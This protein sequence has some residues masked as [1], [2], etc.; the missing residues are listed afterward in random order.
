MKNILSKALM[1]VC[2]TVITFAAVAQNS[3]SYQGVIREGGKIVENKSVNLRLSVMLDDKVYYSEQQV[4]TTN[5]YG[6]V[7]VSVGEGTPLTGKFEDIPWQSMRVMLQVEVST[8]GTDKY[9]NMGSMQIQPVPYAFYA[10]QASVIQPA[11]ASDEP[12][13]QVKDNAGNLLFAVYETGVKVYV[14]DNDNSKAAKS[15]FA[16]AGLSANK[17]EETLLTINADGTTVFVDDNANSKAAKSKFAVSS[18]NGKGEG[19]LLS[20][21]GSGSTIYVG[22]EGK[23]AKSKFAVA[24][25][26]AK[27]AAGNNYS[28]DNDGSTVYVD[29][30]DN[31]SKSATQVLSIDGSS[32]TFYVDDTKEGKAAKSGFAVAG[33]S[34]DKS[35][36]TSLIIDGTGTLIYINNINSD[37]EGASRFVVAGLTANNGTNTNSDKFFTINRD[38]T[39]IYINDAPVTIDT[40]GTEP[41]STPVVMPSLASTFAIV[42]MTQKTD[43]L[44][45]NKDSTSIKV[46]TYVAEEV[47][48]TTGVVEKVVDDT[49]P[50]KVYS[51]GT[52]FL[53]INN[54]IGYEFPSIIETNTSYAYYHSKI[55]EYLYLKFSFDDNEDEYRNYWLYDGKIYEE[56]GTYDYGDKG[57]HKGQN[58]FHHS[59]KNDSGK[60]EV[61]ESRDWNGKGLLMLMERTL[62]DSGFSVTPLDGTNYFYLKD[63]PDNYIVSSES[64]IITGLRGDEDNAS[65]VEIFSKYMGTFTDIIY[66]F[67]WMQYFE[68]ID[69]NT[70]DWGNLNEEQYGYTLFGDDINS[71]NI[72]AKE[73]EFANGEDFNNEEDAFYNRDDSY[74]HTLS[75]I[76]NMFAAMRDGVTVT[77]QSGNPLYGSVQISK[78]KEKYKFGETITITA[79][80]LKDCMFTGWS[81]GNTQKSRT[82]T[83]IKDTELSANFVKLADDDLVDLGLSV[84]WASRNLGAEDI[85]SLG[86]YYVWGETEPIDPETYDPDDYNE[87]DTF[88][89]AA[90]SLLGDDYRVP[91]VDDWQELIDSCDWTFNSD[92]AF[93]SRNG[94]SIFLPFIDVYEEDY[95]S[96]YHSSYWSRTF[97]YYDNEKYA[98]NISINAYSYE[99]D[100]EEYNEVDA[101]MEDDNSLYNGFL[102][103]PVANTYSVKAIAVGEGTTKGSGTYP[104]GSQVTLRAIPDEGAEFLQWS[105]S[106]KTNPRTITIDGDNQTYSAIF[107]KMTVTGVEGQN[108]EQIDIDIATDQDMS[109][110]LTL[111]N[112]HR[113]KV[114]YA[115]GLILYNKNKNTELTVNIKLVGYNLIEGDNHGGLKLSGVSGAKINVVFD[116]ESTASFRFRGY[117]ENDLQIENVEYEISIAN[118]CTFTGTSGGQTFDNDPQGFFNKAKSCRGGSEFTIKRDIGSKAPGTTLEVGD[119][120]FS[121]G[122]ATPYAEG[123]KLNKTQKDS[124]VAIIFYKGTDC[125]DDGSTRTLGIGIHNSAENGTNGRLMWTTYDKRGDDIYSI[126]C[127]PKETNFRESA[128]TNN[129][130]G[131]KNGSNNW[132]SLCG[133]DH[134]AAANA[135]EYYPAFNWA[136]N[137]SSTYNLTGSFANGWYLP[138][139]A[140][141]YYIYWSLTTINASLELLDCTKL[142]EVD[143]GGDGADYWA[144]SEYGNGSGCTWYVAIG[145]KYINYNYKNWQKYVCSIREFPSN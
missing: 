72:I 82:L 103:R 108:N 131:V 24:G 16:V 20:V 60:I 71:E 43:L 7:S 57:N 29:F 34:A 87:P 130:T 140:E 85:F 132:T 142:K 49:K 116:T 96:S 84:K 28:L 93:V 78:N 137:Y 102:I 5:A 15:K 47:Q 9:T 79:V 35:V 65:G 30:N 21:D 120:V 69:I 111:E 14:D 105:D 86:N 55:G 64:N 42:G 122:S 17:G 124:A 3:F 31:A 136:N 113:P 12:I 112:V 89:D 1:A 106:V 62:R 88:Q 48:S 80:P 19:D 52:I 98:Y 11:E 77:V 139:I 121:D 32:T 138:S 117:S 145:Q 58:R 67:G 126:I 76:E 107:N 123:L 38:S 73:S 51:T 61:F 90:T 100:N 68:T 33:R 50:D 36:D 74:R 59:A 115:S 8:D 125:S 134:S 95:E 2:L 144:S 23:A 141:M 40:A 119:I 63:D 75:D 46:D 56:R 91:G 129:F 18:L 39:R 6:N 66:S 25:R 53:S 92:G 101:Y 26:S 81:D 37:A 13:F 118:G 54:N 27:K 135:A 127:S 45:V 44:V 10:A 109:Y 41:G 70:I 22:G 104:P 114:T 94:K 97:H 83:L 143:N 110:N 133:E 128:I 99:E 4:A